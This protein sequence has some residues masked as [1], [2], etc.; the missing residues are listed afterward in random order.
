[1]ESVLKSLQERDPDSMHEKAK[2]R[3][4]NFQKFSSSFV[5]TR[6]GKIRELL[7]EVWTES[8]K[9]LLSSNQDE[10]LIDD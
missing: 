3:F 6:L 8:E 4:Q 2:T 9:H 1:M 7:C 10:G 5:Q